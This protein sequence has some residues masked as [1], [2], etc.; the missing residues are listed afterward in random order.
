MS[1]FKIIARNV[2]QGSRTRRPDDKVPHP[3]G[4]R[5]M[6]RH[7]PSLCTA[8]RTCA[9]VCSPAA[10]AFDQDAETSITS[11]TWRYFAEQC[12]FCGQCVAFC[13]TQ[14]LGFEAGA[15][16]VTG[17]RAQHLLAHQVAYRPCSRCGQ[18]V[19]PLPEPTLVSLYGSPLPP[20]VAA[21]RNLCE[22][23]RSR[24]TGER[25]KAGLRGERIAD[26]R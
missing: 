25:I 18:P 8:C 5:G 10:I 7:D 9:Y 13:P 3:D 2:R 22:R 15:P 17:D 1:I 16:A 21:L 6:L 12:T 11:I 4:F 23:C 24:V 19:V 26:E 14:A 20:E